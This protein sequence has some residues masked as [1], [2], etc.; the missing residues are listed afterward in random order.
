MTNPLMIA[1]DVVGVDDDVLPGGEPLLT[2]IHEMVVELAYGERSRTGAAA[3]RLILKEHD[4]NRRL[5]QVFYVTS[6]DAKGNRNYYVTQNGVKRLIPGMEQMNQLAVITTG[7]QLGQLEVTKKSVPL[8]N[9]ETQQ[10][11]LT[12]VPVYL[13]MLNKPVIV[14]AVRKRENRRIQNSAGEWVNGPEDRTYTEARKFFHTDGTTIAEKKAGS[15]PKF[16]EN[17]K[18]RHPEDFVDDQYVAVE[19]SPAP[20]STGTTDNT[21]ASVDTLFG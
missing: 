12:E 15:P 8:Y 4:G 7:K 2:G 1:D 13:D 3:I 19:G 9:W 14:G 11:E 21:N 5:R 20:A 10:E 6:G 18:S 17:W 16:I